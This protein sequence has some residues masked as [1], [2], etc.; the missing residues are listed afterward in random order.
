[1]V[2]TGRFSAI[3][4]QYIFFEV[5]NGS[6]QCSDVRWNVGKI[7]VAKFAEAHSRGVPREDPGIDKQFQLDR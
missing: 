7:D 1:M 4:R 5:R 6:A 3:D 2:G